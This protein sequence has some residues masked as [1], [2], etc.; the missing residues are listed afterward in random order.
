MA[1]NFVHVSFGQH[2]VC[3][4]EEQN[5]VLSI[6]VDLDHGMTGHAAFDFLNEIRFY[7]MLFAGIKE[8]LTI[9][10]DETAVININTGFCQ[11]NGLVHTFAA[12][13]GVSA[14]GRLRFTRLNDVVHAVHIV[15]IHGTNVQY[16][17]V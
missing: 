9:F 8:R 2:L 7:A 1:E 10:T 4:A 3:A 14:A 5:A 6:F 16:F 11:S 12:Q 13:E 15:Q 17:H